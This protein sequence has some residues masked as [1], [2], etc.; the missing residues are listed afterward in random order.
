MNENSLKDFL[1]ETLL[2]AGGVMDP[3]N[4][5]IGSSKNTEKKFIF[6]EF[7]SIEETSAAIQLDGIRY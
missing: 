2:K 5:I 6:F 1:F 3:G 4:P 7:R